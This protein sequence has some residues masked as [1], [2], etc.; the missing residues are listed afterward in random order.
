MPATPCIHF[1]DETRSMI[2][3]IFM[4]FAFRYES[5][6]ERMN[7]AAWQVCVCVC[8]A[9][10]SGT[11][12]SAHLTYYILFNDAISGPTFRLHMNENMCARGMARQSEGN[13][14]PHQN[15]FNKKTFSLLVFSIILR[16]TDV[17]QT[18]KKIVTQI[19]PQQII[20]FPHTVCF[21]S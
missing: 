19:L 14:N 8:C 7:A 3:A 20:I 5:A 10:A 15:S 16:T 6:P 2:Y 11:F 17:S 18:L 9:A 4:K 12:H 21:F 13:G 1:H